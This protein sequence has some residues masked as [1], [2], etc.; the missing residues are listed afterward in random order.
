M[1]GMS[2]SLTNALVSDT[3]RVKFRSQRHVAELS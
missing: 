2:G 1:P 3:M